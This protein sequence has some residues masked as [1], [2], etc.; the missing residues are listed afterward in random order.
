MRGLVSEGAIRAILGAAGAAA[1]VSAVGT[2]VVW[3]VV[4]RWQI[5]DR[6][7][8]RS[9][10]RVPVPTMG[11]LGMVAGF[12]AGMAVWLWWPG[13]PLMPAGMLP[14]LGAATLILLLVAGD[15]IGRPLKVWEKALLQVSA[16]AVWLYWGPHLES[17]SLPGLGRV[18]LGPWGPWLTALWLVAMCNVYNFMD[19]LDGMTA[20]QTMLVGCLVLACYLHLGSPLAG[21][22]A[23]L[24]ASAGG[25]LAFNLPPARIFMGDVGAVFLGFAVAAL[26]VLGES[27]GFPLWLYGVVLGYYLFD[28]TYTLLRRA[29]RRENLL[30]AHRKHLYQRLDKM[31]WSHV[32]IDLGGLLV[33]LLLGAGA[34]VFLCWSR[35]LG[36]ALMLLVGAILVGAAAWIERRDRDFA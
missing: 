1:L 7:N 16:T 8:E 34:G 36:V 19:G 17:I 35:A 2:W 5:V 10:H 23:L 20:G 3:R 15:N 24:V 29:A 28:T 6:P 33:T 9:L 12:W 13:G 25:F 26:G 14:A 18:E 31:G 21:M 27:D 4:A 11:G 30:R 22:A 32:R